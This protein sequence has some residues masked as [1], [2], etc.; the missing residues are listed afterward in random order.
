VKT[1][2]KNLNKTPE[3]SNITLKGLKGTPKSGVHGM[4]QWLNT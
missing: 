3:K 4:Q 1:G 2:S